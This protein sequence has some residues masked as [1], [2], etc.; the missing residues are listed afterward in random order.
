MTAASV[1]IGS[2]AAGVTRRVALAPVEGWLTVVLVALLAAAVG[3][4]IDDSRWVLGRD[5][6]TDFLPYAA[7]AGVLAGFVAAKTGWPRW[8]AHLAG[9]LVAAFVLP[10]IVGTILV[11]DGGAPPE[12]FRATAEATRT[13]WFDLAVRGL[14]RTTQ[15]GH[16]LLALGI[17]CWATGQF[18]G[19]AVFR[20][21]RPLDAIVVVGLILLANL[22]LTIRDQLGQLILFSLAGLFLLARAHAFDE[23]TAWLRR[24]IGDPAAVR[25]L[26]LRGGTVFVVTAV[27]GSMLLTSAAASAPLAGI[28][29][30]VP[31][32][33][34]DLSRRIERLLPLGGAS[35]PLG[36]TFGEST[37]I[38]G[39]W[40][41]NGD[42]GLK[43][44]L[45]ED[46]DERFYWRAVAFDTVGP[47]DWSMSDTSEV[48]RAGDALLDGLYDEPNEAGRRR[49]TFTVERIGYADS[50]LVSPQVPVSASTGG[51]V[52]ILGDVGHMGSVS[53][54]GNPRSYEVTALVAVL[55]ED[56]P[57]GITQS[58]LRAAGQAYPPELDRYRVVPAGMVGPDA[59]ALLDVAR[60]RARGD[61]PYDLAKAIEA[62][63]RSGA[64]FTYDP[65]VQDLPCNE[66][67]ITECFARY[68][69]GYCQHYATTMAVLLRHAGIPARM[70]EG[71]L[72]GNRDADGVETVSNDRA[73]AWVEVWFPGYGWYKFDP[74]GGGRAVDTPIP[75]GAPVSP[76]PIRSIPVPSRIGDGG[77][78]GGQTRD[79]ALGPLGGGDGGPSAPLAYVV[80]AVLL[81]VAVGS[82][83]FAA[84]QRGPRG[85]TGA[86]A[87][88]RGIGRLAGRFGFAPRPT[89]TVYEYAGA[90]GDVLPASRP[91][92]ETV[93][94]A[95]VEVAYGRTV[96]SDARLRALRDA[97]RRLR[98]A[99]LRLAFR[100]RERRRR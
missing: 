3:W 45:P 9:A 1:R 27:V 43:I 90:L 46:E 74:T 41:P 37:Q 20:H 86:D 48:T 71:F 95:K 31:G 54:D 73:H 6:W 16:Y 85:E 67:G 33:L 32:V 93:A 64:R 19:F 52:T 38:S 68:Q 18:A 53:L 83:A 78:L 76:G 42:P 96:L 2:G 47:T 92:L 94:R 29:A 62:Y 24:R 61:N 28:W 82:L 21:R 100:R 15:Y 55:D 56:D 39:F 88:W 23:Q 4:A 12:F 40:S 14:T 89:Q 77:E 10:V 30:D 91:E 7:A 66:L 50:E 51:T 84:W 5:E 57:G 98:V 63:L 59:Q 11:G 70:V 36:V 72:P 87:V 25:A 80:I 81:A 17:L 60:E 79:P 58:R 65:N 8:S 13:A 75:S 22:S 34:I 35:R 26:Y 99:L 49:V 44:L 69:R 97:H